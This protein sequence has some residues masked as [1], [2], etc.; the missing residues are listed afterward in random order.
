M[1][2]L[3]YMSSLCSISDL[4]WERRRVSWSRRSFGRV[5][6]PKKHQVSVDTSAPENPRCAM[7]SHYCGCHH[8][9]LPALWAKCC[10]CPSSGHGISWGPPFFL[11][12]TRFVQRLYKDSAT[13]MTFISGCSLVVV[14]LLR[15]HVGRSV[16][17]C[18]ICLDFFQQQQKIGTVAMLC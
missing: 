12:N 1:S 10:K 18:I 17:I 13:S 11:F 8:V 9:L 7:A 4:P 14:I 5:S 6:S 15:Q 3:K 2:G 16:E